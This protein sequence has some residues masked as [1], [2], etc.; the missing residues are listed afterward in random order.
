MTGI[1]TANTKKFQSP[2]VKH[3]AWSSAALSPILTTSVLPGENSFLL[4]FPERI[5][6]FSI[7]VPIQPE[8]LTSL[9]LPAGDQQRLLSTPATLLT[10]LLS[11]P[12]LLSLMILSPFTVQWQ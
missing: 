2:P 4:I 7:P 5:A 8:D 12:P 11:R 3:T 1:C 9:F 6:F 10:I